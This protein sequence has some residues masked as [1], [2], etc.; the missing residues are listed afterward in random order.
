MSTPADEALLDLLASIGVKVSV[1]GEELFVRALRGIL[2]DDDWAVIGESKAGLVD[3]IKRRETPVNTIPSYAWR[4]Q[5][6]SWP[7]SWRR[8][9]GM[10]ANRM[11]EEEAGWKEAE[12]R[13]FDSVRAE[14]LAIEPDRPRRRK[15]MA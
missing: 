11:Q 12:M 3:L 5:I 8:R 14:M 9:W 1:E 13:A 4:E 2:S 7:G 15:V 10:L 6:A